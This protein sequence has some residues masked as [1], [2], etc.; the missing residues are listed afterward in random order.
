[1]L[2][3]AFITKFAKCGEVPAHFWVPF[4]GAFCRALL[5]LA[6]INYMFFSALL[7]E[8]TV[9]CL[10]MF[11][12]TVLHFQFTLLFSPEIRLSVLLLEEEMLA[13]VLVPRQPLSPSSTGPIWAR[14][15]PVEFGKTGKY[16]PIEPAILERKISIL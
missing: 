3:A 6:H 2:V 4:I 7:T 12:L 8:L 13:C 10:E 11:A 14:I 1:M 15:C 5:C 9:S 16:C